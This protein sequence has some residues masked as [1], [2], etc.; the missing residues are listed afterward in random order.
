M[1]KTEKGAVDIEGHTYEVVGELAILI[2]TVERLPHVQEYIKAEGFESLLDLIERQVRPLF[3]ADLDEEIV[4]Q[5]QEQ[6][7]MHKQNK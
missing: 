5:I 4:P 7:E 6:D 3:E 1:L 2:M